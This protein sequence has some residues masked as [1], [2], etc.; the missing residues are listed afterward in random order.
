MLP[1]NPAWNA[2]SEEVDTTVQYPEGA[3][4]TVTIN[5]Y[6]RNPK[7]RQACIDHYSAVCQVCLFSFEDTFGE[8]GK[9]YIHVHHTVPL[10][11]I[12]QTYEVNPIEDLCPVCPNCH[13]MLHRK[14]PPYTVEEL[15]SII[16]ANRSLAELL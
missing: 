12:G 9:G 16:S 8:M 2:L 7:A 14:F 6:E 1:T 10:S 13:A 4:L 3:V 5:R 15:Q 11:T